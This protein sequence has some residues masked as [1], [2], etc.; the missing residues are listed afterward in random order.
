MLQIDKELLQKD[1]H[2]KQIY[3]TFVH[4]SLVIKELKVEKTNVPSSN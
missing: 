3:L 4:R 1:K 2:C